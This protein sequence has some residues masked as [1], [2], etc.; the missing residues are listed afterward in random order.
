MINISRKKVVVLS[1]GFL[2]FFCSCLVSAIFL[3][4]TANRGGEPTTPVLAEEGSPPV[5]A[6]LAL[7]S[8]PQPGAGS[9]LSLKSLLPA[10]SLLVSWN[11]KLGE[12]PERPPFLTSETLKAEAGAAETDSGLNLPFL[13]QIQSPCRLEVELSGKVMALDRTVLGLSDELEQGLLLP[14]PGARLV[15]NPLHPHYCFPVS[16]PF[17]F[18]DS[19][20]DPRG[21]TR[22]HIGI[23]IF[24]Q[25]GTEVYAITDGVVQTLANWERAGLTILLRG[26]D[27][28]GY[29]YM[30]LQNYAAGLHE[31]Q[32]VKKGDLIAFVGRTGTISSPPHLHFQVHNDHNFAKDSVLNPYDALV[33][34]CQGRGVADLGRRPDLRVARLSAGKGS[35]YPLQSGRRELFLA[36]A[37]TSSERRTALVWQVPPSTWKVPRPQVR[38]IAPK[39]KT[40]PPATHLSWILP[41]NGRI[42]KKPK[43]LIPLFSQPHN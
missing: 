8:H 37:Q 10:G 21:P 16:W 24:A 43:V 1:G 14:I 13:A 18:R 5:D 19:Y 9:R 20:G 23:D 33:S 29:V 41:I 32:R 25:E 38:V 39:D 2:L 28:K 36:A 17:T 6:K 26:Q 7:S 4:N 27:G 42:S 15:I 35:V 31:G 11:W 30:H 3:G 40:A 12:P 22:R 34:L